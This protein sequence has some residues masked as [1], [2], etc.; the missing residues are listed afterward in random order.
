[1]REASVQIAKRGIK[2]RLVVTTVVIHP[3]PNHG[4]EHPRQIVNPPVD[5]STELPIADFPSDGFGSSIAY[6][7]SCEGGHDANTN[8]SGALGGS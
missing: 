5:A 3:T 8:V 1:M 2:R 7:I 6:V 4:I